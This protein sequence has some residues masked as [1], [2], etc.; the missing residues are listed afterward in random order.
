MNDA[1]FDEIGIRGTQG[2]NLVYTTN[3]IF[4]WFGAGIMDKPIGDFFPIRWDLVL[5]VIRPLLMLIFQT[6]SALLIS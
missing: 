4:R 1:D 2:N 5:S 3:D 6:G